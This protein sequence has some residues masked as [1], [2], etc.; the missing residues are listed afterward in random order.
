MQTADNQEP[1]KSQIAQLPEQ[2][3]LAHAKGSASAIAYITI[4]CNKCTFLSSIISFLYSCKAQK[5]ESVLRGGSSI[6]AFKSI[7][8]HLCNKFVDSCFSDFGNQSLTVFPCPAG[9]YF[10]Q[11]HIVF[12]HRKMHAWTSCKPLSSLQLATEVVSFLA[13]AL[14]WC[15]STLVL[16]QI[17]NRFSSVES[18]RPRTCSAFQ[19]AAQMLSGAVLGK[20]LKTY[21]PKV[22]V[23]TVRLACL[24][25][26]DVVY[27]QL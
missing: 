16:K 14:S 21:I 5:K 10:F 9:L 26:K 18:S 1:Q 25:S 3:Y 20:S 22:N 8:M 12:G 13:S 27:M 4:L 19:K 2:K 15:T 23:S 11:R 17:A 7:I 24:D 6:S